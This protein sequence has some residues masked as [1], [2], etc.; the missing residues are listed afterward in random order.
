MELNF[1][2]NTDV[3]QNNSIKGITVFN[4]EQVGRFENNAIPQGHITIPP[5]LAVEVVSPNDLYCELERKVDEYLRAG[6]RMIWVLNPDFRT[7]RIFKD[8]IER[9]TQIGPNDE[10]AGDDVLPDFRCRVAEL[11]G[12]APAS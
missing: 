9:S 1:L 10:L 3:K 6:V 11:F 7:V 8:S 2:T 4:T 12:Q 5:D